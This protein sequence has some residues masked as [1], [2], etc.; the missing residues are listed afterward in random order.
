MEKTLNA[1]KTHLEVTDT[2]KTYYIKAD[3]IEEKASLLNRLAVVE[4]MLAEFDK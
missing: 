1:E 3:L 4:E 2:V